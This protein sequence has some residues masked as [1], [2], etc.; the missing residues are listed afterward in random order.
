MGTCQHILTV[1]SGSCTAVQHIPLTS[2]VLGQA[3]GVD[4]LAGFGLDIFQ[5][6]I[7]GIYLFLYIA[8]GSKSL[9]LSASAVF[10]MV[11]CIPVAYFFYHIVFQVRPSLG[12]PVDV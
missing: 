7:C 11:V 2:H 8:I 6:L 5:A 1:H 9:L 4:Y 12:L 10:N 3:G